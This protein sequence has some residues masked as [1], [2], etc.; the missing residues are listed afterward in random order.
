MYT[1][2]VDNKCDVDVVMFDFAKA[3]DSVNHK[4]LLH[5]LISYGFNSNLLSWIANFL[6]GRSQSV[7]M[8]SKYSSVSSVPSGVI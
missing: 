8:G 2:S 1:R 5:K 4:L 3:F 7:K 6:S